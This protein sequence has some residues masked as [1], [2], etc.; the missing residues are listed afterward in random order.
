MRSAFPMSHGRT[1]S[2]LRAHKSTHAIIGNSPRSDRCQALLRV[3]LGYLFLPNRSMICA[4]GH[5]DG[6]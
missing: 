6:A 1:P 5:P 2:G 3:N 4:K